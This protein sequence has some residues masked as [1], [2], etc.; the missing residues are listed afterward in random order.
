MKRGPQPRGP[1]RSSGPNGAHE[2]HFAAPPL[3]SSRASVEVFAHNDD[4][5]LARDEFAPWH[6]ELQGRLAVVGQ[7]SCQERLVAKLLVRP[8]YQ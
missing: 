3:T 7:A 5:L 2:V 8:S 4:G 1:A 6:T